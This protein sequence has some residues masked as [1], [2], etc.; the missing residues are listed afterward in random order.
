MVTR[1][2]EVLSKLEGEVSQF[3]RTRIKPRALNEIRG[4]S[5]A[6]P[7]KT[8][9]HASR[10]PA[11]NSFQCAAAFSLYLS[12]VLFFKYSCP[13]KTNNPQI[14]K[15]MF[16]NAHKRN[17]IPLRYYFILSEWQKF[18]SL[19]IY[20]VGKTLQGFSYIASGSTK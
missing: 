15:M 13:K 12:G 7:G 17:K 5:P 10:F 18:Q 8:T 16:N 19:I 2:S 11:S 14:Y 6:F 20:W 1:R 4:L 9:L 3:S